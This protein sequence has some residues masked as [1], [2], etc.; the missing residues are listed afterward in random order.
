MVRTIVDD[1][2]KYK[3]RD[4]NFMKLLKSAGDVE[5]RKEI[6]YKELERFITSYNLSKSEIGELALQSENPFLY[7]Q[8]L[9]QT[10][11]NI[12]FELCEYFRMWYN[13]RGEQK[14][15]AFKKEYHQ[16]DCFGDRRRCKYQK[17]K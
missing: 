16:I 17:K 8:Y 9:F 6:L 4:E 13:A 1:F 10:E 15:C 2:F 7:S 11:E 3:R 14:R 5:K 12:D